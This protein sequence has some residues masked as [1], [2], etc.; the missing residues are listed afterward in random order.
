M[1]NCL[2]TGGAGFIG[3]HL[4]EALL[5]RGD[6]VTVVDDESTGTRENLAAVWDHERLTYVRGGAEDADLVRR[7]TADVDEVYHLAAAVGVALVIRQPL[8]TIKRN[9]Y[10]TQLLLE[11]LRPRIERGEPVRFFLASS[12]E[13]YGKNPQPA[14]SEEDDLVIGPTTRAR[15]SYGAS[16]AVDEFMALACF[17]QYGLPVVVGRLFNVIGPRQ[18]GAYG[19]VLPRF[20]EAALAGGPLTV[21]DDGR[22]VRCFA[23]VAD[24][25]RWVLQLMSSPAAVGQIVNIGGDQPVEIGDLARRVVDAV[26]PTLRIEFQSYAD[27]YDADFEDIR[28]RVPDLT[29]LRSLVDYHPAYSLDAIIQEVLDEHERRG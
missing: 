16:K 12:S 15:W 5:A 25:V 11:T 28:R 17:R 29:R 26:D 4:A 24:V 9:I 22:Q 19:M 2:V 13:V 1:K 27:A 3:S 7:V 23:H 10:P 14:F 6:R 20:V 18:T 21:Y 8:E